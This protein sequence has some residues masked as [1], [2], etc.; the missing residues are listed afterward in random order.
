VSPDLLAALDR[1]AMDLSIAAK[2]AALINRKDDPLSTIFEHEQGDATY[3]TPDTPINLL[4]SEQRTKASG[5]LH[6]SRS[7][8][9]YDQS[10]EFATL[11]NPPP[12][13]SF[14]HRL[15]GG[16]WQL[17]VVNSGPRASV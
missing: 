13:S 2:T 15:P 4:H 7:K 3:N 1:W 10:L 17:F 9:Q 16:V 11:N 5:M 8:Q 6:I 14:L 12:P